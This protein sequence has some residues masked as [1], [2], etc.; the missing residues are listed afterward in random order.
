M[1]L[2]EQT[3]DGFMLYR[4]DAEGG[5]AGDTWHQSL[6]D[7]KHQAEYEYADAI[8]RWIVVPPAIEDA[9]GYILGR[10]GRSSLSG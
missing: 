7:A 6:D 1:I 5:F 8:R 3:S 9:V 10:I 4:F 2:I